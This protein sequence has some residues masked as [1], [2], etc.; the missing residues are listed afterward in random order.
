MVVHTSFENKLTK[1]EPAIKRLKVMV[2]ISTPVPLKSV[3][4]ITFNN[5]P[6]EQFTDNLFSSGQTKHSSIIHPIMSRIPPISKIN[7]G[8]S[9]ATPSDDSALKT[10][11]PLMEQEVAQLIEKEKRLKKLKKDNKELEKALEKMNLA[12]FGLE[13]SDPPTCQ[14]E[15]ANPNPTQI[16]TADF[17]VYSDFRLKVK[18]TAEKLDIHPPRQL[19]QVGLPPLNVRVQGLIKNIKRSPKKSQEQNTSEE[20]K[21]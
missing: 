12:R 6:Y 2:G 17:K 3:G 21:S 16:P 8:K 14:P 1:E 11:M 5:M 9:I 15:P 7:K 20:T 18:E 10:I 13:F 19:T 4:P